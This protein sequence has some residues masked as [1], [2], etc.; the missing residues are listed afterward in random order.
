MATSWPRPPSDGRSSIDQINMAE[1]ATS[2]PEAKEETDFNS[3][4]TQS[5]FERA[6]RHHLPSAFVS[7]LERVDEF[8]VGKV[9]VLHKKPHFWREKK[10]DFTSLHISALLKE[11]QGEGKALDIHTESKKL[12]D[13]S[14]DASN[15]LVKLDLGLDAELKTSWANLGGD[16]KG[17]GTK[18]V[19]L[20]V[21][22]GSIYH[23]VSD[24]PETLS[25]R[26]WTANTGHAV[27]KDALA[28]GKEMFVITSAYQA[29]KAF[30]RVG[31]IANKIRL[32]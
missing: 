29:Q 22:F 4:S 26:Q 7:L 28:K 25:S 8:D 12:F 6:V 9:L 30:V 17:G 10:L 18:V 21:D 20:F 24:L 5:V 1:P 14:S 3:E 32:Q 31:S 13:Q 15:R 2:K 11:V 23:I 16:V 27:V 19:H